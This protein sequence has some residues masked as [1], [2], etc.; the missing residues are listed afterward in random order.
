MADEDDIYNRRSGFSIFDFW[1]RPG[2]RLGTG[3]ETKTPYWYVVA[4]ISFALALWIVWA[5]IVGGASLTRIVTIF[6]VASGVIF[7]FLIRLQQT[8]FWAGIGSIGGAALSFVLQLRQW[9]STD[10]WPGWQIRDLP[11]FREVVGVESSGLLAWLGNQ[12]A[13]LVLL[14]AAISLLVLTLVLRR[15]L[16]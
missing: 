3:A 5:D 4:A 8:L 7:Y 16:K 9:F 13:I 11:G 1:R 12:S 14:G 15:F 10:V 2:W 6:I